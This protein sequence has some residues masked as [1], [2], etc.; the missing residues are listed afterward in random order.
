MA[1]F[2]YCTSFLNVC[3]WWGWL[4]RSAGVNNLSAAR[5]KASFVPRTGINVVGER[6]E[7]A[8]SLLT[9]SLEIQQTPMGV[10]FFPEGK[11]SKHRPWGV[12]PWGRKTGQC[13]LLVDPDEKCCP[14]TLPWF[15]S[16]LCL[17]CFSTVKNLHEFSLNCFHLCEFWIFYEV[18]YFLL[19]KLNSNNICE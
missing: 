15:G 18:A 5:I 11:S 14:G 7:E 16:H 10:V 17:C 1:A 9:A 4:V 13:W 2:T 3:R 8:P 19:F 6:V 12:W